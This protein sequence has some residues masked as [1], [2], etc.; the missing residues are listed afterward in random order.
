MSY[1][2]QA[3][4]K[5]VF[6]I[7]SANYERQLYVSPT[8]EAIWKRPCKTLYESP[9]SFNDTIVKE[10]LDFAQADFE[11]RKDKVGECL[12]LFRVY[13]PNKKVRWMKDYSFLL[14][15]NNNTP[16]AVAGFSECIAENE[17]DIL[18]ENPH[19]RDI[20]F[21]VMKMFME[22]AKGKYTL[23]QC[24]DP[25]VNLFGLSRGQVIYLDNVLIALTDRESECLICLMNGMSSKQIAKALNL[26]H[27][28]VE[29]YII[30]LR[31]K[32]DSKTC[33]TMISKIAGLVFCEK[34][35]SSS[36]NKI[37]LAE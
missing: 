13:T 29:S 15:D 2:Y 19:E 1:L 7:R 21:G 27:R 24:S 5:F 11:K 23:Q 32:A 30:N 16:I 18:R 31:S 20:E 37:L 26:S 6:W 17:W 22:F 4:A 8:Y 12:T 14:Y 25:N 34:E 36:S 3:N 10:D 28:T 35:V 9:Q 33:L